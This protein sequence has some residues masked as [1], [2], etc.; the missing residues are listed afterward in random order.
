MRLETWLNQNVVRI[1]T[2]CNN[3]DNLFKYIQEDYFQY[4]AKRA[5]DA[6]ASGQGK[7]KGKICS[8]RTRDSYVHDS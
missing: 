6:L 1:T 2:V 8:N 5:T 7:L 3:C 4:E